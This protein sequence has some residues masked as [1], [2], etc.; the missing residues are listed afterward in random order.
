MEPVTA[1]SRIRRPTLFGEPGL[2]FRVDVV[3]VIGPEL[4]FIE[5]GVLGVLRIGRHMGAISMPRVAC[6][7]T[8]GAEDL[9]AGP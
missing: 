4:V 2:E 6:L 1:P 5:E 9:R 3:A 7:P 8:N